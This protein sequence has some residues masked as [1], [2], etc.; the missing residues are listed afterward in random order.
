MFKH[1][2]V[3]ALG[4]MCYGSVLAAPKYGA[5]TVPLSVDRAYLQKAEATDFWGLIPYY[6]AQRD[7]RSCSLAS[8]ATLI[9]SLRPVQSLTA[10]DTLV[11]QD[12]LLDRVN[13]SAWNRMFKL[14][15]KTAGLDEFK[16]IAEN[17][18][19]TYQLKK[20]DGSFF[21]VDVLRV[22]V[23]EKSK[24]PTE[25]SILKIRQALITNEKSKEDRMIL[26]ALQS[27]L[28]GDPEGKVGHVM[29]IGAFDADALSKKGRVLIL[30]PDREYYEPYW[31]SFDQMIRGMNTLDTDSG[32]TRGILWIH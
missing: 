26:N 5:G 1:L 25:A 3:F 11:T 29:T 22:E 6:L 21:Q 12:A 20:P 15:G 9:N 7:G 14:K 13:H 4:F 18:I 10:A 19:K 24:A 31:V 17:A 16:E 23:D 2:T 28:T 32:K 8:F 30:D 27:E